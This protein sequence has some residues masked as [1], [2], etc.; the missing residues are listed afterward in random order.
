VGI[1]EPYDDIMRALR[2]RRP[3]YSRA[4]DT[5]PAGGTRHFATLADVARAAAALETI[6][7]NVHVAKRE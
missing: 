4:L 2:A 1:E 3:E 7:K 5:P 6:A